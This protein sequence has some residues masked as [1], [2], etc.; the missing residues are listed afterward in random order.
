MS[1]NRREGEVTRDAVLELG[2]LIADI[3]MKRLISPG[4]V[5]VEDAC[6]VTQKNRQDIGR[7]KAGLSICPTFES[8]TKNPGTPGALPRVI[9]SSTDDKVFCYP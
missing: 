3:V 4:S 7:W 6:F 5:L 9:H 1:F 8:K 2:S